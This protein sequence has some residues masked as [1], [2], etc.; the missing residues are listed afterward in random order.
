MNKA[1]RIIFIDKYK[2]KIEPLY[3]QLIVE[4]FRENA[5]IDSV[6]NE[7]IAFVG[8]FSDEFVN[9]CK[10]LGGSLSGKMGN[11]YEKRLAIVNEILQEMGLISRGELCT[12]EFL[13][14]I[15]VEN[16][17]KPNNFSKISSVEFKLPQKTMKLLFELS[18]NLYKTKETRNLFT[19]GLQEI[20]KSMVENYGEDIITFK[21]DLDHL[22]VLR[23]G[24][25]F[26]VESKTKERNQDFNAYGDVNKLLETWAGLTY[27]M[28]DFYNKDNT[29][30]SK[31]EWN[32]ISI[33]YLMNGKEN[34]DIEKDI[35]Y[36]PCFRVNNLNKGGTISA[37][38]FYKYF[39]DVNFEDI[40][41]VE[42]LCANYVSEFVKQSIDFMYAENKK[43][44]ADAIS[45]YESYIDAI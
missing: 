11:F 13:K 31:P 45:D 28:L 9:Y 5:I 14:R 24:K 32:S 42:R 44:K 15:G 40:L 38:D 8:G 33:L 30:I 25:V 19:V 36:F 17:T 6:S 39:F 41:V 27:A 22:L 18:R 21:H 23:N 4:N 7:D 35:K 3:K 34:K 26:I 2:Q 20:Y 10:I 1:N 43:S 12:E 16:F 29:A 37:V